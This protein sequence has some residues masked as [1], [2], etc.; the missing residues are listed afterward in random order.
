MFKKR[1][2]FMKPYVIAIDFL[3][4]LSLLSVQ[5]VQASEFNFAVETILPENQRDSGVTYFDLLVTPGQQQELE[6]RL[7]NETPNELTIET[8]LMHAKTNSNGIVAYND[9]ITQKDDSLIVPLEE[10]I[11]AENDITIPANEEIIFPMQLTVPEEAFDGILLGGITLQEKEKESA[12]N[13]NSSEGLTIENKFAYTIGI[14]LTENEE[15]VA[16]ELVLH[17]VFPEQRN[18]RNSIAA[19]IQNPQPMLMNQ[20]EINAVI[21][22]KNGSDVLFERTAEELQMAPNSN[23]D[24]S[25]PLEGQEM[26]PG[27][28]TAR[29][30]AASMGEE[31]SWTKD[32]TISAEEAQE[33][34]ESDVSI[35]QE[36]T[37]IFYLIIGGLVLI[38]IALIIYLVL[39]NRKKDQTGPVSK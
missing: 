37:F 7:R 13:D 34:N 32:F 17:D 2:S 20:M 23:F 9:R 21:L 4:L 12:E 38:I 22:E 39:K 8:V 3:I 31:W 1:S 14:M 25:I 15:E 11:E 18:Y 24:F 36:D 26:V 16:P 30:T 28:Y 19:N 35:E 29:I 33:Y 6:I 27:E 10:L 5:T